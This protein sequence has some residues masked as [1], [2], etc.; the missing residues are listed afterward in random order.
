MV[1]SNIQNK[2]SA[3]NARPPGPQ[4]TST[5]VGESPDSLNLISHTSS[6]ASK[7][8]HPRGHSR[9]CR[10]VR[11]SSRSVLAAED[12]RKASPEPSSS[13]E[14]KES[15]EEEISPGPRTPTASRIITGKLSHRIAP[16]QLPAALSP[17]ALEGRTHFMSWDDQVSTEESRGL[18]SGVTSAPRPLF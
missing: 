12:S 3:T 16:L 2:F 14:E 6:R 18:A 8:V 5:S 9:A 15:E 1:K 17:S 13:S 10:T 11:R 7:C 4:A